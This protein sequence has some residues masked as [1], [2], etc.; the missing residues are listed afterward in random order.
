MFVTVTVMN[1]GKWDD[2]NSINSTITEDYT[3]ATVT[4]EKGVLHI[5]N[6]YRF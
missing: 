3:Q 2:R 6:R 4:N 1:N 5:D